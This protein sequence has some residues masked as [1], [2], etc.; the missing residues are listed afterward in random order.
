MQTHR[1]RTH[2]TQTHWSQTYLQL[3]VVLQH[4]AGMQTALEALLPLQPLPTHEHPHLGHRLLPKLFFKAT[5]RGIF[6]QGHACTCQLSVLTSFA[7]QC[8]TCVLR[9]LSLQCVQLKLHMLCMLLPQLTDERV[10]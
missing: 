7:S 1:S 4:E 8:G 6:L 2:W 10:L 9:V 5:G 3:R